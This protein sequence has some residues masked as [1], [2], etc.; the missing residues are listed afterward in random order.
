[1]KYNADCL[2]HAASNATYAMPEI[3]A[4]CASRTVNGP[5][6]NCEGHRITLPQW[7]YLGTTLHSRTLLRQDELS[8]SEIFLWFGKQDY[9]LEREDEI[10]IEVL[11]QAVE[12]SRDVLQQQRRRPGLTLIMTLL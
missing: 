12:I 8:A 11:M 4:I 1:M 9:N 10:A 2:T 6:V 5:V 7:D 3:D